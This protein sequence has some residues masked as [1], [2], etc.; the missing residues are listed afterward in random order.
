M[1]W[2]RK[3]VASAGSTPLSEACAS[4][5]NRFFLV[6]RKVVCDSKVSIFCDLYVDDTVDHVH[7]QLMGLDVIISAATTAAF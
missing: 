5:Q 2:L 1:K 3:S 4:A 6:F 7:G